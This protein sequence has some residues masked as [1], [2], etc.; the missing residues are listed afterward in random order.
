MHHYKVLK[1]II[2]YDDGTLN[3]S[4][5]A[6]LCKCSVENTEESI[7]WLMKN[8]YIYK[9]NGVFYLNNSGRVYFADTFARRTM[10]ILLVITLTILGVAYLFIK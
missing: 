2:D 6:E 9:E 1:K 10:L 8:Q 5:L 3:E 4:M 7:R